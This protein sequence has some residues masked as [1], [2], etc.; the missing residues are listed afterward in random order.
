MEHDGEEDSGEMLSPNEVGEY[1]P[2]EDTGHFTAQ[3]LWDA[4]TAMESLVEEQMSPI[5]EFALLLQ[6]MVADR[7]G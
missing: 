6:V 5:E 7:L 2:C 4:L 1:M 3:G